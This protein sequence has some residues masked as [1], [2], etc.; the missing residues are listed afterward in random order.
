MAISGD[1]HY[2]L[3]VADNT[4]QNMSCMESY[5]LF[6]RSKLTAIACHLYIHLPVD[7]V[8]LTA[9]VAWW[10]VLDSVNKRQGIVKSFAS[11]WI[12]PRFLWVRVTHH[13]SFL[14]CVFCCC[15][16]LFAFVLCLMTKVVCVSGM[17]ILV[18]II[19]TTTLVSLVYKK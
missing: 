13:L 2:L 11:T 18:Y 9:N 4:D 6:T 8:P 1:N 7:L 16:F 19:E 3:K 10:G 14:C 17:P 15:F 12:Q 5:H